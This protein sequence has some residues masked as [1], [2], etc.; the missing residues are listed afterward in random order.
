VQDVFVTA[1]RRQRADA[2]T[3]T[4]DLPWLLTVARSRF[5]DHVRSA[6]SRSRREERHAVAD[7][8]AISADVS[9]VS[10]DQARWMLAKL[11]DVER[12]S[13]A[14]AVVDGMPIDELS[15]ILGRSTA[16][17]HSLLA[18]ARRRLRASLEGEPQ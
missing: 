9:A 10:A 14:L 1:L 7:N 8:A 16:A 18:R 5:I 11:P 2:P 4:V 6:S 3:P 15:A 13:L 12:W 17:T